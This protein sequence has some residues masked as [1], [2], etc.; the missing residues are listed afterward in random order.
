MKLSRLAAR[1]AAAWRVG[2]WRAVRCRLDR[3]W[4]TA[5]RRVLRFD[6][7]HAAAPYSCRPYKKT[8]VELA[9]ALRPQVAVEVGCGLGDILSRIKARERLGFDTELAVVRAARWL[10][11]MRARWVHGDATDVLSYTSRRIDCLIMVNWIHNLSPE[12][13]AACLRPLLPHVSHLIVDAIH[14]DAPGTY[15]FRHDFQFLSDVAERIA[16]VAVAAEPRNL[17]VFK[18]VG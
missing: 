1:S 2:E 5:L 18:I 13:L 6:A 12:R 17:V 16:D 9:N 3:L 4:L 8:V 14:P 10:H 11:P 15:R 7:W